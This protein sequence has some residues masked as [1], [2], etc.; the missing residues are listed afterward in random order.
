MSR[1]GV[2]AA[3]Y[4]DEQSVLPREVHCRDDIGR[5]RAPCDQRRPALMHRVEDRLVGKTRLTWRDD[6][7]AERR[8]K[9]AD[10]RVRKIDESTIACRDCR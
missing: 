10:L 7:V 3:A 2:A 4:S 8:S 1:H 6:A 9:R 5:A